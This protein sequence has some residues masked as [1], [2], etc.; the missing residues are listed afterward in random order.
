MPSLPSRNYTLAAAVK[1]HAKVDIKLS[2]SCPASLDFSTPLRIPCPGLQD[3]TEGSSEDMPDG[4]PRDPCKD[5][6]EVHLRPKLRV[7]LR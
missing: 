5:A 7:H 2:L 1:K 4:E 3:T 6:Q